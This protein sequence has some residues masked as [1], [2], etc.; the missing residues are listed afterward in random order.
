MPLCGFNKEMLEGLILFHKGLV[1][2]GI[3]E[4]SNIKK[5]SIG[6][7]IQN[8]LSDM[9]RFQKEMNHIQDLKI[10]NL[11][12][13]LTQYSNAFYELLNERGIEG[14]EKLIRNLNNFYFE[15]DRKFYGELE[16]KPDDMKQLA[17]HLDKIKI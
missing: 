10:Q 16:G 2:H 1:E 6:K 8:E 9:K 11:T 5:Q 17:I 7:T 3:I 13:A 14:Y 12:Q 15:M 4:R